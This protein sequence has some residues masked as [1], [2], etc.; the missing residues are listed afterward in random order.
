MAMTYTDR[1]DTRLCFDSAKPSEGYDCFIK[2][3]QYHMQPYVSYA[4]WQDDATL[5][6]TVLYIETPYVVTY[7]IRREKQSIH[8]EYA[9]NVSFG[10]QECSID[11]I[12]AG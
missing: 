10:V 5:T 2:D 9:V 4:Q 12:A 11:G 7:M 1:P 8:L 3:V 6:L